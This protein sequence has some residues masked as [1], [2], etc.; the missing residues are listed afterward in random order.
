MN[1]FTKNYS[2]A[3]KSFSSTLFTTTLLLLAIIIFL[4]NL[5]FEAFWIE[6]QATTQVIGEGHIGY[7]ARW[8]TGTLSTFSDSATVTVNAV[9]RKPKFM[10][11]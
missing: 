6:T 8:I 9:P 10:E 4:F 11:N 3:K 2:R 5:N 1:H 7:L